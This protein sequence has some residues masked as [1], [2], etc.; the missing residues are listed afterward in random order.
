MYLPQEV[1][2]VTQILWYEQTVK[3]PAGFYYVP[4]DPDGVSIRDLKKY[5]ITAE[6][7]KDIAVYIDPETG[8][9]SNAFV[10]TGIFDN[11]SSSLGGFSGGNVG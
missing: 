2:I 6:S 8:A 10:D 11:T 4:A 7:L 3:I 9:L 5:A 1:T